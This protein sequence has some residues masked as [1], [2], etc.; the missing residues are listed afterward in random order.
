MKANGWIIVVSLLAAFSLGLPCR[1]ADQGEGQA[2]PKGFEYTSEWLS[3][4]IKPSGQISSVKARNIVLVREMFLHGTY[5]PKE[6]HDARF[7]QRSAKQA[8]PLR[9]RKI[10]E[11]Q[12]EITKNGVLGNNRY[13]EAAKYSQHV[14]LSP[15]RMEF[16]YEVEMLVP[17]SSATKIFLTL[18]TLPADTY[19]NRG[20]RLRRGEG[21]GSLHV[22][23]EV[24]D[25]CS[26]IRAGGVTELCV[27]LDEG[28][29]LLK[30]GANTVIALSDQ[31][32][33]GSKDLRA[34]IHVLV[35]WRQEPVTHPAGTKFTWSFS[36]IFDNTR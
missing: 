21:G 5:K 22:F 12:Y 27:V 25:K 18:L 34:D 7:F 20:Y 24:Y 26:D 29:F 19:A 6:R 4:A 3:C 23:P 11:E 28:H 15:N 16:R 10:G 35:P 33:W 13:A 8:E 9:A 30:T 17:L 36:L 14:T 32:S 2:H 31:R 1:A